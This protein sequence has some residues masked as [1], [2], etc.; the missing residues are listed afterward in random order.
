MLTHPFWAAEMWYRDAAVQRSRL[1]EGAVVIDVPLAGA[2]AGHT[3]LLYRDS[4]EH[5]AAC[6]RYVTAADAAS[7]AILVAATREHLDGL[8]DRLP[9]GT[10]VRLAELTAHGADPGRVLALIRTFAREHSGRPVRCVQDVG[11]QGRPV[12]H[13]AEAIRYEALL[14]QALAGLPASMLCGYNAQ[15]GAD[16]LAAGERAHRTVLEGT[17]ERANAAPACGVPTSPADLTLS[18]PPETAATL[19]FRGDQASVRHLAAAQATEAGLQIERVTDL[20]LAVAELAANTLSHT[21]GTGIL[22]IWK[23]GDELLCQVSD[24]GQIADPLAGT[25]RAEA[26]DVGS[27]RGLWLVHQVSDLVQVRTGSGGTTIRLH[28]GLV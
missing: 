27:R 18:S 24:S 6:A 17:R 8:R 28:M 21:D 19:A 11:W 10:R 9:G 25:L 20:V 1:R 14:C 16:L 7:E 3:M 2:E 12:E 15:L 22:K 23:T 5:A 4:G 13:L 26:D